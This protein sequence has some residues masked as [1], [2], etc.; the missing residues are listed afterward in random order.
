MTKDL[1]IRFKSHNEFGKDST[2][3]YRPWIAIHV[4]FFPDKITAKKREHYFKQGSGS[5]LK[6]Q[7]ISDFLARWAHILH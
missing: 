7:I 4:E 5:R 3:K 6:Q 1:L 2:A